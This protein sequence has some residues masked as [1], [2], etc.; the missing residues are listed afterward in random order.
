MAGFSRIEVVDGVHAQNAHAQGTEPMNALKTI[1]ITNFPGSE[2]ETMREDVVHLLAQFEK[3]F[4]TIGIDVY[5]GTVYITTEGKH[6]E[7]CAVIFNDMIYNHAVLKAVTHP[8]PPD[9][10]IPLWYLNKEE[11]KLLRTFLVSVKVMNLDASVER[12]VTWNRLR[13]LCG[14]NNIRF[15]SIQITR[16]GTVAWITVESENANEL[17]RVIQAMDFFGSCLSSDV[18]AVPEYYIPPEWYREEILASEHVKE[19]TEPSVVTMSTPVHEDVD[20]D[21]PQEEALQE[22]DDTLEDEVPEYPILELNEESFF[23][24]NSETFQFCDV[25]SFK[26]N[27]SAWSITDFKVST[28]LVLE[29][30]GLEEY[31]I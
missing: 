13:V 26:F 11:N 9:Y 14:Q 23:E 17:R 21:V 19:T 1:K 22:E 31:K 12:G 27:P 5:A 18:L 25:P 3:P 24:K 10:K 30:A 20:N 7:E 16:C 29:A 2:R 15:L 8:V 28:S 4:L 6:A